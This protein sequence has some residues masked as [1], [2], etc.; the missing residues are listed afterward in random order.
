LEQA[1]QLFDWAVRNVTLN[2]D[3]R[4]AT[5]RPWQTLI[6]GRGTA[7]QRAWVFAGLCR[8]R[9]LPTVVLQLPA[10]A[11]AGND[12]TASTSGGTPWLWCGVLDG[13][14][15]HLFDPQLGLP[16][17]GPSG[18]PNGGPD[19]RSVATLAQ[20]QADDT[21]LRALDLP[22][23]A[24]PPTAEAAKRAVA[25]VVADGFALSW[26][27]AELQQQ[28]S[29]A[30]AVS[31]SIDADALATELRALPSVDEV[32]LWPA[33]A[34][35]VAQA[36]GRGRL[37]REAIAVEFRPFCWQPRLWKARTLHLR[38][39]LETEEEAKR[40]NDA[41]YDA[42][43]D[44]RTAGQLYMSRRVRPSDARLESVAP[45]KRT[46]YAR[47][48]ADA[49]YWLGL[50][51]YELG[52]YK[53]S[54]AR[55][56]EADND[57]DAARRAGGIR[58]NRGRALEALGQIEEAAAVFA[59]S[60]SPQQHGDRLRARRLLAGLESAGESDAASDAPREPE[61][62]PEPEAESDAQEETAAA[63]PA[64]ATPAADGPAGDEAT[65]GGPTTGDRATGEA[66]SATENDATPAGG[67]Q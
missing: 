42:V 28:L 8:Q 44:H 14:A 49:T 22:G 31:L 53:S 11:P 15:L 51:Q 63:T 61:G 9:G 43:N 65:A 2:D 27:A 3:P 36:A 62:Q 54:L 35:L 13:G 17:P 6:Y 20:V 45:A 1:T 30:N 4:M 34:R 39:A 18:G 59:A 32:R 67:D 57:P 64:A 12:E 48:K 29:A 37:L 60:E 38:G 16:V 41:L 5:N 52:A 7:E 21:L 24:Y 40:R 66:P 26:R 55:L 58:Y 47:G 10:A 25:C 56:A 46:I 50:L 23:S 19:G 33:P